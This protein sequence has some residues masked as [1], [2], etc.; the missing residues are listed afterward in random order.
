MIMLE[1]RKMTKYFGGL[2]A[3]FELDLNVNSGEIFGLIG[4]NGSGKSTV[5]NL[6]TGVSKPTRG[7]IIYKG[8]DIT[9]FK[10]D[11]IA[12]KRIGRTF[13]L[14]TLFD[15]KTVLENMVIAFHLEYK[16]SFWG[17]ILRGSSQTK[18]KNISEKAKELLEF[19]GLTS[20]IWGKQVQSL[21]H[22][23]RRFL[24]LAM[25]LAPSPQL[26]LLDEPAGGMNA[27]EIRTMVNLM[28]ILKER[29][30][31]IL[32]VEH[33]LDVIMGL[34]DRIVAINFGKKIGE[35]SCDEVRE[36]R[37]VIEAYIGV[38]TDAS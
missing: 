19:V 35:G 7:R 11:K 8:E 27:E 1:T 28:K 22:G 6:I 34:C 26:L 12:Q 20:D 31:T 9:G 17:S 3:V 15:S 13:Q 24:G 23:L 30:V 25:A 2:A 16:S 36:N 37:D 14:P 18:E 10:S 5:F 33:H 21:P 32:L 4:P 38:E 29:G